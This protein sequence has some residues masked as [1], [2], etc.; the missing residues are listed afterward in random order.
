MRTHNFTGKSN[1]E[2]NALTLKSTTADM[3]RAAKRPEVTYTR[4]QEHPQ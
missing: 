3:L 1:F 4:H 2:L